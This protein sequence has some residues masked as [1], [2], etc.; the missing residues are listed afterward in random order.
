MNKTIFQLKP[1]IYRRFS[2][3]KPGVNQPIPYTTGNWKH[4]TFEQ[5]KNSGGAYNF[6]IS[7]VVPRPI[8][9]VSTV[10]KDGQVNCAPFSYFNVMSHDPPLLVLGLNL[11]S[12]SNT[13]KDTLNNIEQTGY[14]ILSYF[15]IIIYCLRLNSI[16]YLSYYTIMH[17]IY[18]TTTVLVTGILYYRTICSEYN[19]LLVLRVSQP[20]QWH[21]SSRRE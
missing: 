15:K 2:T 13:K 10:N 16:F 11:N 19:K 7:S 20:L 12:R 9:L 6:L 14:F 4:Y 1:I 21:V 5:L 3:W 18:T 8:A 17:C